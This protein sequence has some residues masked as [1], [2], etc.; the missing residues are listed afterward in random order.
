MNT[1]SGD[2]PKYSEEVEI[3]GMLDAPDETI[4]SKYPDNHII[5]KLEDAQNFGDSK[6][7]EQDMEETLPP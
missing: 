3:H 6:K 2:N 4:S 5:H 1:I 7:K